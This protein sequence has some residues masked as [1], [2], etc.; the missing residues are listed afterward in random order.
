MASQ[1]S[2]SRRSASMN[3]RRVRSPKTVSKVGHSCKFFLQIFISFAFSDNSSSCIRQRRFRIIFSSLAFADF[4][5]TRRS[6]RSS[7]GFLYSSL[8]RYS[9]ISRSGFESKFYL[10]ILIQFICQLLNQFIDK[11]FNQIRVN[12]KTIMLL[13]EYLVN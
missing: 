3:S 6:Y 12:Q 2:S 7:F 4:G 10:F 9:S 5:C 8:F 11:L 1:L 13:G